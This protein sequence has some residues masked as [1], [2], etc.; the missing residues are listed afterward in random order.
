MQ[1]RADQP[2]EGVS[3]IDAETP[4]TARLS[5]EDVEAPVASAAVMLASGRRYELDA[6]RD[7]DKVT[8]RAR[9]GEVVLRIEVTDT[10]PVLSFSGA[11]VELS[12]ARSLHLAAPEV[13]IEAGE[14]LSLVSGGALRERVAGDHHTRVGGSERV[15]AANVELQANT[16]RVGVRAMGKIALDGEHI[17]LNDDPMPQPFGWSEPANGP[18]EAPNG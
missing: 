2:D 12:A 4:A 17:G 13:A 18:D 5:L 15:E 6:G 8:I 7:A 16:G 11:T 9:N 1:T 10:G 3:E 14:E